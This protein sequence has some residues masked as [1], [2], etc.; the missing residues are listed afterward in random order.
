[1][2]IALL[3]NPDSLH[4]QRW[5]RFLSSRG[6]DLRLI[7][8]PHTRARPAECEIAEVRW[9]L[10]LNILAFRL[11][12]RPHGNALWKP[13]L[14]RPLI[15]DFRPDVVHGFEAYYNGL[16]TG[17]AGP[18]PK[19]LSPWGRDIFFDGRA[20]KLGGWMVR[21]ALRD[22]DRI[23]CNDESIAPF[24]E[25]IYGVP[26]EKVV[27]FSWGIDLDVFSEVD[28]SEVEQ[29][30]EA[31]DIEPETPVIL[32]PRK[33]GRLWGSDTIAAALPEVLQASPH[34][35]AVLIAPTPEDEEAL[36]LKARLESACD[37]GRL[38]WLE[39]D[40]PAETMAALFSLADVFISTPPADLLAQTVLEGMAC[41]CFPV[42]SRLE[43]YAKHAVDRKTALLV[44]AGDPAALAAALIEALGHAPLREKAARL[45]REAM[46]RS[47]DAS[48]NMLKMEEVYAQAIEVHGRM[49]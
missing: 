12:P 1:M 10:L 15:T 37:S 28:A 34:A 23:T 3:G 30:R 2:R 43:A 42:L 36:A 25:E 27:P 16:A 8:D 41:G 40:Q 33:W 13:W 17:G 29:A 9:T 20:G 7:V 22:V 18:Y 49:P 19:V 31:L 32:S 45:N 6:H 21:R 11:T 4:V 46:R 5:V 44:N 24:L 39:P 35:V 38:R 26:S 14:Y 47:E 48:V